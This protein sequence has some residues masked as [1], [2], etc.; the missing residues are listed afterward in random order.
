[1]TETTELLFSYGTLQDAA[2]QQAQ[3]GRLLEGSADA[4]NGFRIGEISISDP[5]VVRKS[6]KAIHPALM[7]DPGGSQRI[8]GT[9]YWIT[10]QELAAADAYEVDEYER[11]RVTM[12]SGREAWVYVAAAPA[13]EME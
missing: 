2:V 7:R 1:M 9:L 12:E 8:S 5:E 10:E 11:Q 13:L 4:L 3:F 6:G